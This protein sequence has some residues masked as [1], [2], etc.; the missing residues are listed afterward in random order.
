MTATK[1]M[2]QRHKKNKTHNPADGVS[3]SGNKFLSQEG[4]WPW[5]QRGAWTTWLKVVG[6]MTRLELQT[7]LTGVRHT[8]LIATSTLKLLLSKNWTNGSNKNKKSHY[9]LV[10][11][12]CVCGGGGLA[13]SA[14]GQL[15]CQ[16]AMR[17]HMK[18]LMSIH[19]STHTGVS[20]LLQDLGVNRHEQKCQ[21]GRLDPC[22]S[23][24]VPN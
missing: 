17:L 13:C 16:C 18:L 1:M 8:W 4:Y 3:P 10:T 6:H 7:P 23:T 2:L 20:T 12:V 5:V 11:H 19:W 24:E 22:C 15:S 14:G 9:F 21:S